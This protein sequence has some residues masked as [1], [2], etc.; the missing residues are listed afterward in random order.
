[1]TS[2]LFIFRTF[3]FGIKKDQ[4]SLLDSKESTDFTA[5]PPESVYSALFQ[6]NN[7]QSPYAK[8]PKEIYNVA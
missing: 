5:Q 6:K 7:P 3:A 1:M 4:K 8:I 2:Q